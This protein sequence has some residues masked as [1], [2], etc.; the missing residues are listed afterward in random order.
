LTIVHNEYEV[1]NILRNRH[2]VELCQHGVTCST[3][4]WKWCER[5]EFVDRSPKPVLQTLGEGSPIKRGR[6]LGRI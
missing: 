4:L 6:K 1:A 5:E 2:W 3:H